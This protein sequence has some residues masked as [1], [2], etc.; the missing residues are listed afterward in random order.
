MSVNKKSAS[1]VDLVRK[2]GK[3]VAVPRQADAKAGN[4]VEIGGDNHTI[5]Q[6]A[7]G[8]IHNH[9]YQSPPRPAKVTVQPGDDV[10]SEAQKST[11]TK[12]HDEWVEL[13]NAISPRRPLTHA[14]AWKAINQ[15]A[16]VTS[17]HRIPAASYNELVKWIKQQMGRLR[18][19][20]SAPA[21]DE[22]WRNSKIKAIKAR[23]ANQLGDQDA[24]K[25]YVRKNFN[26]GSLTDLATEELQR[27]Y[28]YV[29]AKK[30]AT[31]AAGAGSPST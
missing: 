29:M 26:A 20:R 2:G 1:I 25:A 21:K 15:H 10:V 12:L 7:G 31:K 14:A 28:A 23:C 18:N 27:T 9:T 4:T 24:Y 13:D 17:Y 3:T 22:F 6:I 19:H 5:G 30:V 16:Q 11:L 8:D